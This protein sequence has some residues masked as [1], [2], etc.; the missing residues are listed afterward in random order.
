LVQAVRDLPK[1][2]AWIVAAPI[3]AEIIGHR[4]GPFAHSLGVLAR[5]TGDVTLAA[6]HFAEADAI[7]TRM[8]APF[9]QARTW[10]EW[11]DLLLAGGDAA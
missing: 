10:V 4:R 11:A 7:N 8:K 3:L 6:E 5:T 1:E 2:S 9:F